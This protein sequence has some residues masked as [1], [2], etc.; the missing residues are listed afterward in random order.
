LIARIVQRLGF[1]VVRGS[2]TRQSLTA[3]RSL[4]RQG[5]LTNLAITPDGPLGPRRVLQPGA[6]YVASRTGLPIFPT[7]FA[8]RECWR[9]GSWDRMAIPKLLTS[10]VGVVGR[11]MIVEPDLSPE[12]IEEQ[13]VVL[14]AEMDRVQERAETEA[15]R[16]AACVNIT[17]QRRGLLR[18]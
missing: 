15:Q 10:G 7:G 4:V 8:F 6:V 14:Q 3:V 11:P 12:Q 16:D 18:G 9:A 5:N 1:S 2:T 17:R 13:R